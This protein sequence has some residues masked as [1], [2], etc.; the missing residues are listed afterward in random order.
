MWRR[1]MKSWR[2]NVLH[3]HFHLVRFHFF[4]P[5]HFSTRVSTTRQRLPL[6]LIFLLFFPFSLSVFCSQSRL[7]LS[8]PSPP[9][10]LHCP[11]RDCLSPI[12]REPVQPTILNFLSS[13]VSHRHSF[14]PPLLSSA[15]YDSQVNHAALYRLAQWNVTRMKHHLL[16]CRLNLTWDDHYFRI[17]NF[18]SSE[19]FSAHLSHLFSLF[20]LSDSLC[21]NKFNLM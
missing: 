6:S 2:R 16:L 8:F 9:L 1:K 21:R 20:D 17:S 12:N 5:F 13:T 19:F 7:F 11:L 18:L 3:V 14:S 4:R 15:L 10:D